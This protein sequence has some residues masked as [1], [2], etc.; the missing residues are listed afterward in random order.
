MPSVIYRT[1]ANKDGRT[2]SIVKELTWEGGSVDET[3]ACGPFN[4]Y[5]ETYPIV[6]TLNEALETGIRKDREDVA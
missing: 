3:E 1:K 2:F 4:S 6:N 5:V